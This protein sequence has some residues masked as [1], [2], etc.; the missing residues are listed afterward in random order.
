[1]PEQRRQAPPINIPPLGLLDF[2][3][4]KSG[5]QNP[6]MLSGQLQGVW[7]IQTLYEQGPRERVTG[8]TTVV[9]P[10]V[11]GVQAIDAKFTVP[12][13]EFW[14]VL[15][16]SVTTQ[17]V[18]LRMT[19]CAGCGMMGDLGANVVVPVGRIE[20]PDQGVGANMNNVHS[21]HD[22]W[23][24]PGAILLVQILNVTLA[25]N[26]VWDGVADIVRYKMR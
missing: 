18:A 23:A 14:H 1:M 20:V 2:L 7:D 15:H 21:D 9:V 13:T 19:W 10:P 5:G 24:P 4:L 6:T 8:T 22:F 25:G 12:Q 17:L 3:N 11:I 26:S 16:W